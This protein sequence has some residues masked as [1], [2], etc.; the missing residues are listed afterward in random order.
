MHPRQTLAVL[1]AAAFLAGCASTATP[2]AYEASASPA[3]A[4]RFENDLRS[5]RARAE[6]AVGINGVKGAGLTQASS[7]RGAT[8][9]V[10]EAVDSLVAG[11]RNA[12]ARA[13]GAAAGEAAGSVA[14]VLLNWNE[15]DR[16]HREFVDRCLKERGHSVLGWR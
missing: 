5:C 12:W 10:K 11:S 7:R 2:V 6:Q 8:A 15:P 4:A 3:K 9:F 13:R 1:L 14:H 16:V